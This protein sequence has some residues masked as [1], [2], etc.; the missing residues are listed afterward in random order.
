MITV[1]NKGQFRVEIGSRP[2]DNI[3]YTDAP[4]AH[5][6]LGEYPTPVELMAESLAACA[7]TTLSMGAARNGLNIESYRAEVTGIDFD[8]NHSAVT[9]V[10]LRFH[11]PQDIE[12]KLRKKLEAFAHNACT[13]GNTLK[14]EKDFEFVYE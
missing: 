2:A 4:A 12:P 13:V 5:N 6:G 14:C 3:I 1:K 8:D 9:R 7:L 10:G 11:L